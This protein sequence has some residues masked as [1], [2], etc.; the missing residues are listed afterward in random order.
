MQWHFLQSEEEAL[1]RAMAASVLEV[2]GEASNQSGGGNNLEQ[3]EDVLLARTIAASL[4]E[5][6]RV[7]SSEQ[8]NS[9]SCNVC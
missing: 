4:E 9:N 7:N 6:R 2:N 1:A 8:R 3:D 5:S